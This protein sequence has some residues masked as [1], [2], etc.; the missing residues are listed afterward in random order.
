MDVQKTPA[1]RPRTP[2]ETNA[3][4]V[5]TFPEEIVLLVLDNKRGTFAGVPTLWFH[6]ALAGGVLMEL[7]LKGRI[8]TDPEKLVV[9]DSSPIGDD[10]LDPYLTRIVQSPASRDAHYWIEDTLKFASVIRERVLERL[11]DCGMLRRKTG[12]FPWLGRTLRYP[13]VD[14]RPVRAAKQRITGLLYSDRIPDARDIVI[15]ALADACG[16]FESLLS[17]QEMKRAPPVASSRSAR[18]S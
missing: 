14:T 11:V 9:I 7:A 5:L 6:Y 1:D 16:L 12:R 13:L 2:T 17:D 4:R 8:D 3:G 18:W 10:L 15:I